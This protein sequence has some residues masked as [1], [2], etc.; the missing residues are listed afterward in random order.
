[1]NPRP[2]ILCYRV[3]MFILLFD[4]TVF[5]SNRQDLKSAS[6]GYFSRSISGRLGNELVNMT[7]LAYLRKPPTVQAQSVGGRLP[8]FKRLERT[9]LQLRRSVR[10]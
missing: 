4:L 1:M 6:P 7:T 3:Y 2:R 5:T 8:V 10:R 9:L